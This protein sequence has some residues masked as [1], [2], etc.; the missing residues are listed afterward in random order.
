MPGAYSQNQSLTPEEV[1]AFSK[2]EECRE[3]V[4]NDDT[5][6]FAEKMIARDECD[7]KANSM[8]VGTA[9]VDTKGEEIREDRK[10]EILKCEEWH[11]QYQ[12][13]SIENFMTLKDVAHAQMCISLYLDPIWGYEGD[14]RTKILVEYS[15]SMQNEAR[16]QT[17][18]ANMPSRGSISVSS[19]DLMMDYEL[20]SGEIVSVVPDVDSTSLI[21]EI[22]SNTAGSLTV[23]LPRNIL[24]A[25]S[26]NGDDS[27]SVLVD[28]EEVEFKESVTE[29]IRILTI[30][31]PAGSEEIEI[32]GTF[33]VPEFG[34]VA[35]MIL[36]ITISAVIASSRKHGLL[37]N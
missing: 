4:D 34:A 13:D 9:G 19:T 1:E 28:G 15:L 23:E 36:A 35:L 3:N 11:S 29:M 12:T 7:D 16:P 27:F 14:D 32:I 33:V 31:Y 37:K 20:T 8:M 10:R 26:N 21:I 30:P 22:N 18:I 5:L 2:A 6:T 24:D 25:K 17:S